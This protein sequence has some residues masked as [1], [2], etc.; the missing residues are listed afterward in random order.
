VKGFAKRRTFPLK[1]GDNG[2]L[3]VE[4]QQAT[5]ELRVRPKTRV[6][7]DGKQLGE[8]PLEPI[9]LYEG[10]HGLRL[11]SEEL[12][13]EIIIPLDIQAGEHHVIKFDLEK[14]T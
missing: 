12:G 4:V 9:R 11:E 13:K 1:P 5:L 6:F 8:T 2:V 10:K 3:L 14:D 7:L